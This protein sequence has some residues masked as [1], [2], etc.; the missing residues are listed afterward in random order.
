MWMNRDAGSYQLSHTWDQWPT[1]T[2]VGRGND[3]Q[4][5]RTVLT[6]DDDACQ[7]WRTTSANNNDVCQRWSQATVSPM[8]HRDVTTLEALTYQASH[9]LSTSSTTADNHF[10]FD[11]FELILFSNNLSTKCFQFATKTRIKLYFSN[12][13]LDRIRRADDNFAQHE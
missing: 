9:Q 10:R 6:Y 7:R 2:P 11:N 1:M 12:S 3:R 5:R 4:R 8:G 13:K